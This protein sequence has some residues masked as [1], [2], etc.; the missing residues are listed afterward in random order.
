MRRLVGQASRPVW[1]LAALVAAALLSASCARPAAIKQAPAE[2]LSVVEMGNPA[3]LPQL[4]HGFWKLESGS[5]RWAARRFRVVLEAPPT[6]PVKGAMMELHFTLPKAVLTNDDPVTLAA[7]VN[8]MPLPSVAFATE[9]EQVYWRMVPPEVF[10]IQP[11]TIEFTV[12]RAL[13]PIPGEERE[14]AIV[15]NKI[16][17]LPR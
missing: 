3:A 2:L 12:D 1:P 7:T 17:L 6:A 8:G 14:L 10:Q 5:W 13:P 11:V 16:G 15:V 9:G 4:V